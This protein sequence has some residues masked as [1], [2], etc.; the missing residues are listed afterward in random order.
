MVVGALAGRRLVADALAQSVS[1]I[2]TS[3]CMH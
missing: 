3:L 2:V 1:P